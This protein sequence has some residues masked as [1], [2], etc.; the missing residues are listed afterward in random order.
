MSK[1]S[2]FFSR[3]AWILHVSA[4]KYSLPSFHKPSV[5]INCTE[6]DRNAW[7]LQNF[8]FEYS[9]TNSND[10]LSAHKLI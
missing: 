9:E 1:R 4:Y 3:N 10:H 5:H 2:E 8:Q 7:I 6:F